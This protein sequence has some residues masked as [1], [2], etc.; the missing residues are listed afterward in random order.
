MKLDVPCGPLTGEPSRE[1]RGRM[2]CPLFHADWLGAVFLHYEVEPSA[3]QPLV[4]FEL[5]LRENLA[6]VSL[7]AF[8]MRDL[9][10]GLFAR[11]GRRLF[12]P[13][14]NHGF[15]NARTYVRSG[16]DTGIYFLAEWLSN[17]LTVPL[18]PPLFG[19]P[20]HFGKTDYRHEPQNNRVSGSVSAGAGRLDYHGALAPDAA[21]LPCRQGSLD[22]FLLERYTAFT[23]WRG[24]RRFFRVWHPPW[25]AARLDATVEEAS[26]LDQTGDWVSHSRLIAAHYSPGVRDVW[27]GH[28][29]I[30]W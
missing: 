5:H 24:L 22:E 29:Q 14:S 7:V 25:H 23:Y 9:R 20:Y 21:P 12:L 1:A 10:P 16:P 26:L 2:T 19:L 11:A 15:L 30:L 4:P 17:R 3:L 8:T 28:P 13:I 6:Y 27:M 18:G